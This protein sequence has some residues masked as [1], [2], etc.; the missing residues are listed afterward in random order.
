MGLGRVLCALAAV[1]RAEHSLIPVKLGDGVSVTLNVS[2]LDA[3]EREVAAFCAR[4]K[5]NARECAELT[6]LVRTMRFE[7]AQRGAV[8]PTRASAD[9]ARAVEALDGEAARDAARARGGREGDTLVYE[10]GI[11]GV[12]RRIEF[13]S[14]ETPTGLRSIA[15][16]FVREHGLRSGSGCDDEEC[17]VAMLLADMP[18][19]AR[20][21]TAARE[22]VAL[23]EEYRDDDG[24]DDDDDDELFAKRAIEELGCSECVSATGGDACAAACAFADVLR[25]AKMT[26]TLDGTG[27]TVQRDAA[28]AATRAPP[29]CG[30][31]ARGQTARGTTARSTPDPAR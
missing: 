23:H 27:D 22:S 28:A 12:P 25:V 20:P 18:R 15:S 9:N 26:T 11:G 4:W 13:S 14:T 19:R 3:P 2:A 30:C 1:V 21:R 16:A 29:G 24:D 5:V 6:A 17:V 7:E 10:V 8:D 31:P